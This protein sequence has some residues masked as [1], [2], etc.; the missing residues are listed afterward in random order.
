MKF[1][2]ISKPKYP[3]PP[4]RVIPLIDAFMAYI[5]KYEASGQLE[6]SWSYAGTD[7]GGG[8]ANVDSL[9]ELDA[10]MQEYPF[11]PFSEVEIIPLTDVKTS[12]QRT[13]E[14]AQMMFQQMGG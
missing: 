7:S 3:V 9:E 6:M 5:D 12:I 11:G 8:I 10:I 13:K 14:Y 1:L 4:E 2:V